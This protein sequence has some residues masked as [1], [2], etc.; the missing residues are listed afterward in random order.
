MLYKWRFTHNTLCYICFYISISLVTIAVKEN[1]TIVLSCKKCQPQLCV[2]VWMCVH[3]CIC[4]SSEHHTTPMFTSTMTNDTTSGHSGHSHCLPTTH[5][6]THKLTQFSTS[7]A[8]HLRTDTCSHDNTINRGQSG[9][10]NSL[11]LSSSCSGPDIWSSFL[12]VHP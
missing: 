10:T 5:T 2:C 8:L 11:S 1:S 6:H 7:T 4:M 12:A 9:V 3:I